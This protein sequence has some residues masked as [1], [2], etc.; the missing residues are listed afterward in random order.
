MADTPTPATPATPVPKSPEYYAAARKRR[1]E[2]FKQK[3]KK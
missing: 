3:P 1:E 2:K